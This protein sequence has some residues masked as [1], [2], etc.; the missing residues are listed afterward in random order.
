MAD[1]TWSADCSDS[2]GDY[3]RNH[4]DHDVG[5]KS[6]LPTSVTTDACNIALRILLPT[7]SPI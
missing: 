3:N 6:D 7:F 4:G 1:Y 2:D 5:D